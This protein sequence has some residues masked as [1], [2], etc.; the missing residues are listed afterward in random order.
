MPDEPDRNLALELVRVTE[1]AAVAAAKWQ[2]RGD[3]DAVDQ[4]AVDAMR[5]ML[6][7]VDVDGIVVIGEGEKDEAPSLANG[8]AVGNGHGTRMDVAVDPVDGTRLIARGMPGALAVIS[9]AERGSMYAPGSLVYMDKIAVGE[10]AAGMVDLEAPVEHN[11]SQVAKAKGKEIDEVTAV[12][13]NRPRNE[14]CVRRVREAGARIALIGDG[15]ISGA[16]ATAKQDSGIDILLGI[17]GS[18]EAVTAACAMLALRGE[19]QCKLWPRDSAERKYAM[20]QG[21]D[22]DQ[23]LTTRDLV[24]SDNTFFAATGVTTGSL[25]GGVQFLGDR[26][27]T[28][29]VVMRS[30]SGTTRF[31]EGIH[32]TEWIDSP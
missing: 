14:D 4:A 30:S 3:K 28:R 19:L 31:I 1:A 27:K 12:I 32:R 6:A 26:I 15:D 23:V 21:L 13:L 18:P 16:I 5:S 17:G 2:G 24:N 8:E 20:E 7:T 25:L 11:L 22:L 9:M 29:S 10:A